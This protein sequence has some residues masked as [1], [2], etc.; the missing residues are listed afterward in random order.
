M[1]TEKDPLAPTMAHCYHGDLE[2]LAD[3]RRRERK[4]NQKDVIR[5]LLDQDEQNQAVKA[6]QKPLEE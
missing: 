1:S 4:N 5:Y 2:R 3:V 6:A